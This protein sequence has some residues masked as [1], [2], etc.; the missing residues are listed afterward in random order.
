MKTM[1]A[2]FLAAALL[3]TGAAAQSP[4][5]AA[6]P[7]APAKST[8]RPLNL[9]LDDADVRR[10]VTFSPREGGEQRAADGLPALGGNASS[11]FDR[12]PPPVPSSTP[13]SP[14]PKD[15]ENPR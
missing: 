8:P 5:P 3:A 15:T 14:F 10:A 7:Q 1:L 4:A 11:A 2:M 6:P 9:K 13:G 12:P